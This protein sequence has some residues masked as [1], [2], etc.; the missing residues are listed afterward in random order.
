MKIL[1]IDDKV[2]GCYWY[3]TKM[4]LKELEKKGHEIRIMRYEGRKFDIKEYDIFHVSRI[5]PGNFEEVIFYADKIGT[6]FIYD[7]D[8]ALDLVPDHSPAM[9]AV[10]KDIASYFFMLNHANLIT[11][12]TEELKNHLRK[13][14]DKRIEVIPNC[15]NPTEFKKRAGGNERIKIG[16]AGSPT[17]TK[18]L[19]TPLRAMEN[20]QKKYDFDFFLFG[21]SDKDDSLRDWHEEVMELEKFSPNKRIGEAVD[22]F[23][24]YAKKINN[25]HWVPAHPIHSYSTMLSMLNFDIGICPLEDTRFNK[26]KSCIKYYEYTAVDTV[27]IASDVLPYSEEVE[28]K[29]KNTITDWYDVL[30]KLILSKE[31]RD[32]ILE[33]QKKFVFENR[34]IKQFTQLREELYKSIL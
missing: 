18:D 31:E 23:T 20:L 15:I 30:E 1:A 9:Y 28:C 5:L 14:T 13:F 34:S 26:M 22:E 25:F 3:R 19:I 33:K 10:R 24:F 17:H 27:C 6:K 8:D 12:T 16:F 2:T 11:T 29:V 32:L 7:C 21:F 4:P